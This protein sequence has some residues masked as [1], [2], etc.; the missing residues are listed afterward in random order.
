M[1][2]I[3]DMTVV[4]ETDFP[5]YIGL[6]V[7]QLTKLRN[8]ITDEKLLILVETYR[9]LLMETGREESIRRGGSMVKM[10]KIHL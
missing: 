9:L 4:P 5:G 10:I 6:N 3:I 7:C 2:R 1:F 8:Q